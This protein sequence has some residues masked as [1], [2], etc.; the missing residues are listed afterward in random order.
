MNF[1]ASKKN[2]KENFDKKNQARPG[3]LKIKRTNGK[4]TWK[5]KRSKKLDQTISLL[6]DFTQPSKHLHVQIQ[7]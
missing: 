1:V 4:F 2:V 6:A 3:Q 7:Q 5:R